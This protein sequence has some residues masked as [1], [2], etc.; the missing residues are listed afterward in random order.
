M[1]H[2]IMHDRL[3]PSSKDATEVTESVCSET[4]DTNSLERG[5]EAR[6]NG[7]PLF[8]CKNVLTD[9]RVEASRED[10]RLERLPSYVEAVRDRSAS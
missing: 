10:R 7:K 8:Q 5:N 9:V 3:A 1:A 6:V 4:T 2:L